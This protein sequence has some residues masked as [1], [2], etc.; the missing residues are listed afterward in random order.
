MHT[1]LF[2]DGEDF[3]AGPDEIRYFHWTLRGT[4]LP[5]S[6]PNS[7]FIAIGIEREFTRGKTQN[8]MGEER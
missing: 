3:L 4:F 7:P 5:D 8:E 2:G 6:R 1:C